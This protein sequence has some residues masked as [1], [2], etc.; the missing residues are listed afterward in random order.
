MPRLEVLLQKT[1]RRGRHGRS[2]WRVRL[3]PFE[4]SV[5]VMLVGN[6][7]SPK[8]QA[9]LN[10]GERRFCV[11]VPLQVR[12]ILETFCRDFKEEVQKRAPKGSDWPLSGG[13]RRVFLQVE[14]PGQPLESC[15]AASELGCMLRQWHHPY[16]CRGAQWRH[17]SRIQ[18]VRMADLDENP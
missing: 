16:R 14:P 11:N 8:I 17:P 7:L 2:T 15:L 3:D 5:V 13:L 4:K 1:K 18:V 10:V 9:T 6:T 12:V